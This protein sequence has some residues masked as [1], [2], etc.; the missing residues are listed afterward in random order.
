MEICCQENDKPVSPTKCSKS[1][2]IL[3]YSMRIE[4][5]AVHQAR[6]AAV[7]KK[8]TLGRWLEEVIAEKLEREKENFGQPAGNGA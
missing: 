7:T 4:P 5:E 6:I 8:K 3:H 1:L 2:D